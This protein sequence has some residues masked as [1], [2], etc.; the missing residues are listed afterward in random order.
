MTR[1]RTLVTGG[2][3]GI[4]AAIAERLAEAGHDLVLGYVHDDAAAEL[5]EAA[6][7]TR[8][9]TC[10]LVRADLLTDE[11]VEDLF[12]AMR[13]TSDLIGRPV[14]GSTG[15][16]MWAVLALAA[17]MVERGETGSIVTLLC[18]GGDRY[19]HTYFDD[20]WVAEHDLDPTP[21]LARLADF[22]RTGTFTP[23]R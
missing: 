23:S 21:Y 20:R 8:G 15:T 1:P 2:T 4:G 6:V 19:A 18:D 13:W 3:R 9:A 5:A 11:G 12:A 16:N 22:T 7:E 10:T 17:Q 14:G